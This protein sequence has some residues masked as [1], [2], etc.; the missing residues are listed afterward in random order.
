MAG[1][2]A[3]PTA[4]LALAARAHAV[5]RNGD[6]GAAS[7][8]SRVGL[9]W[10]GHDGAAS[11]SAS[12]VQFGLARHRH[13]GAASRDAPT[14]VRPGL[15][16]YEPSSSGDDAGSGDDHAASGGR[17]L[18]RPDRGRP[19]GASSGGWRMA[20]WWRGPA[21]GRWR[22]SAGHRQCAAD[23]WQSAAGRLP[24]RDDRPG[25]GPV[26]R[27]AGFTGWLARTDRR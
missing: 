27:A 23:G 16:R 14:V 11:G 22:P 17:W 21:S 24:Q 12:A 25:A 6:D 7:G 20:W 15:A 8:R 10:H 19:C 2:A 9:A 18:A 3:D 1:H 4:R 13:D 5:A 26:R